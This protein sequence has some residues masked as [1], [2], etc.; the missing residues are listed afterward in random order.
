MRVLLALVAVLP[1]G[2]AGCSGTGDGPAAT[3][4]ET[5]TCA[6]PCLSGAVDVVLGG[7]EL[8]AL[9]LTLME[10]TFDPPPGYEPRP[11]GVLSTHPGAAQL[12]HLD[13]WECG[14]STIEG[15]PAGPMTYGEVSVIIEDP[16]VVGAGAD[17]HLF[18]LQQFATGRLLDVLRAQGFEPQE[19][20]A[21]VG[22]DGLGRTGTLA[23]TGLLAEVE[24]GPMQA[25]SVAFETARH[26]EGGWFES[27]PE[28]DESTLFSSAA[29]V[30]PGATVLRE[31]AGESGILRG[32][33]TQ[34]DG[35][36]VTL[37]FS[38]AS[39]A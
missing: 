34:R 21:A 17:G 37:R 2:L 14:D 12:A 20:A 1:L 26:R 36:V 31:A 13:V 4:L 23:D 5:S 9:T 24:H 39:T 30:R 19:G 32:G 11:P 7:C 8:I 38:G 25:G 3:G 15:E 27:A 29:T 33:D 16:Q 22:R 18:V 35:C 10:A 28:C 6:P